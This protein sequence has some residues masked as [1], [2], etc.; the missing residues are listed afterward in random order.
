MLTD[1][2]LL[3]KAI[4]IATRVHDG[5]FDKGGKPYIEHCLHVMRNVSDTEFGIEAQI[6][7]VLHDVLEDTDDYNSVFRELQENFSG[8]VVKAVVDLT[9]KKRESYN[10]YINRVKLNDLAVVVKIQDLKHNMDLSRL[11]EITIKDYER[12]H[13][14]NETLTFLTLHLLEISFLKVATS[15]NRLGDTVYNIFKE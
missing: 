5:Q 14:Y 8:K 9:K 1:C 15:F 3:N 6:V 7:G 2:E 10:N 4:E 13:K 12:Y 11:K